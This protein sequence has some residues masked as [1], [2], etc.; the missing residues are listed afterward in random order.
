MKPKKPFIKKCPSER[1]IQEMVVCFQ[2]ENNRKGIRI[3]KKMAHRYPKFGF[4]W[5]V[6][7]AFLLR[8]GMVAQACKAMET[9]RNLMPQDAEL[10]SNL[11]IAY[12]RNN[13][14]LK[15]EQCLREALIC[16]PGS[17]AVHNNLGNLLRE[18]GKFFEA[19]KHLK[20]AL[21]LSPDDKDA[22]LNL[23]L[24]FNAQKKYD[25][26]EKYCQAAL[27]LQPGN[28]EV[29]HALGVSLHGQG[30]SKEAA[31]KFEMALDLVPNYFEAINHL[32]ISLLEQGNIPGAVDCFHKAIGIESCLKEDAYSNLCVILLSG[33]LSEDLTEL[34]RLCEEALKALPSNS[35]WRIVTFLMIAYQ[36]IGCDVSEKLV[37]RYIE[38]VNHIRDRDE[39]W[40]TR[41][42]FFLLCSRLSD[43]RKSNCSN[44]ECVKKFDVLHVVGESHCLSPA[45]SFVQWES[46]TFRIQPQ[47]VMG[48]KMYHLARPQ[49]DKMKSFI[50]RRLSYVPSN[51]SFLFTIGEI[52]CRPDEGFWLAFSKG[53]GELESMI[54]TT[55]NGYL[56]WLN[57]ELRKKI[58]T[59]VYIQGIPAPDYSLV[60]NILEK[61]KK[62][63]F[64][65]VRLANEILKRG[66]LSFGWNFLDVYQATV[67]SDGFSNKKWR[68][69]KTHLS[70]SFYQIAEKFVVRT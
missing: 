11:G 33:F 51:A 10:L 59:S 37:P 24:V 2:N 41:K 3:A 28:A 38:E 34:I 23:G 64:N 46:R 8:Q 7:G 12:K 19:I 27:Q 22:I 5:K 65:M 50:R 16:N 57:T 9:A 52:D 39:R 53:K 47:F 25:E 32:G 61:D 69:D 36:I 58:Y 68:I 13:C 35:S 63:Y 14:I 20:S 42:A 21:K 70:P 44:Y 4:A 48:V 62:I 40:G 29:W 54:V 55:V 60:A 1:T 56:S 31:K 26:S 6:L 45:H 15:A 30:K 17:I 49:N 66:T 18:Q 67:N 43:H